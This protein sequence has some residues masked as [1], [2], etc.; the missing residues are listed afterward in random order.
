MRHAMSGQLDALADP[1]NVNRL[2]KALLEV[3]LADDLYR[4]KR[5][6]P[7][8]FS[9]LKGFCFNQHTGLPKVLTVQPA[10]NHDVHGNI[11]VTIPAMNGYL[12][13][14]RATHLAVKAV[15]VHAAPGFKA[16]TATSSDL[17]LHGRLYQLHDRQYMAADV[18]AVF[19]GRVWRNRPRGRKLA[20]TPPVETKHQ[21][22][23]LPQD[24]EQRE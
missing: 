15:A 9:R 1:D 19:G 20:A 6:V 8:N 23:P 24:F 4:A 13:H 14:P 3:L 7:A 2:N 18:I 22:H 10:V 17:E 16:A 11:L 21:Y 12:T 5:F